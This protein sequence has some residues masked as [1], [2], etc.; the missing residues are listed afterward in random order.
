M[1]NDTIDDLEQ[2]RKVVEQDIEALY[3]TLLKEINEQ[4]EV[5]LIKSLI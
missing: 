4:K 2:I 3:E 1:M 5:W